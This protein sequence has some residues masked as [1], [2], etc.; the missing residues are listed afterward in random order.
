MVVCPSSG[1]HFALLVP[2]LIAP[3]IYILIWCQG[4]THYSKK[5]KAGDFSDLGDI[6]VAPVLDFS[7]PTFEWS[8]NVAWRELNAVIV[9]L[10]VPTADVQSL[11]RQFAKELAHFG[12][13]IGP[14]NGS[15]LRTGGGWP[16]CSFARRMRNITEW[17]EVFEKILEIDG[18]AQS[19][20]PLH[21][22]FEPIGY[23]RASDAFAGINAH[24]D[25]LIVPGTTDCFGLQSIRDG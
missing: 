20:F 8:L 13:N 3:C 12:D 24:K 18:R 7:S 11:L 19:A 14:D 17:A 5:F 4:L 23:T 9:R 2:A 21:S 10:S 16:F 1:N 25:N 6:H 15:G 22:T